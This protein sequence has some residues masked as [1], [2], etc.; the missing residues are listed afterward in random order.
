MGS[1]IGLVGQRADLAVEVA[2][3]AARVG[4]DVVS[5]GPGH[6]LDA[7]GG[8]RPQAPVDLVLVDVAV[9][10]SAGL[11]GLGFARDVADGGHGVGGGPATWQPSG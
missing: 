2:A 8:V 10:G 9:I 4:A 3:L 1:R 7:V 5:L 11:A 6:V